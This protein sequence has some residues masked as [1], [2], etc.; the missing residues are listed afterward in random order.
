MKLD[1]IQFNTSTTDTPSWTKLVD[2]IYP[3]NSIYLTRGTNTPGNSI[4]GNWT[5][6]TT[7][8]VLALTGS[9]GFAAV[10]K[11]GGSL[12]IS[13]NQMPAH[14]HLPNKSS[15]NFLMQVT[16]TNDMPTF[17]KGLP[18]GTSSNMWLQRTRSTVETGGG[19]IICLIITLSKDTTKTP[20]KC[21]DV[22]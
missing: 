5:A 19:R 20:S 22:G 6:I 16:N 3:T 4:G 10:G 11:N 15:G 18:S 1:A 13:V 7:G 14:S 12:K 17:W 2:L 9:N 21:G 8:S